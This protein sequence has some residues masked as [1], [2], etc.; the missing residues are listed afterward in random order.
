[1][2]KMVLFALCLAV[3]VT[4]FTGC[5]GI[6]ETFE[7]RSYAIDAREVAGICVDVRDR[8]IEVALS[9]DDQIHITYYESVKE[10]YDIAVSDERVLTMTPVIDKVWTD[11]IGVKPAA[12]YR[13]ITLSVPDALLGSLSLSTTNGNL[14]LPALTVLDEAELCSNGGDIVFDRLCAGSSIVL[15]VKNGSITGTVAGG[16]DDYAMRCKTK[17][18]ACNLPAE[19]TGGEKTLS[20]FANN[21]DVNIAFTGE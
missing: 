14:S 9:G 1:M 12:G 21:G 16:Y 3:C 7:Q 4:T 17:K 15:N 20:V 11:Y 6:A 2:K 18:G 10:A 5:A 8:S 13:K 19:K